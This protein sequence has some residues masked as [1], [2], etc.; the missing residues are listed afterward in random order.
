M[1]NIF[2]ELQH[3]QFWIKDFKII[4]FQI[5]KLEQTLV[6]ISHLPGTVQMDGGGCLQLISCPY[7]SSQI[8]L[9]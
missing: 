1:Y 9:N 5:E 6:S 7:I 8:S 2:N 3:I 4:T